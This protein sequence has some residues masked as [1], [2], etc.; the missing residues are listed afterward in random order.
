VLSDEKPK[1]VF[2]FIEVALLAE[3]ADQVVL[4]ALAFP[5]LDDAA[6]GLGA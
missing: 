1:R 3:F 6:T 4:F 2:K 5:G